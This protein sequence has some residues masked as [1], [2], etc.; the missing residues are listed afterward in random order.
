METFTT[1]WVKLPLLAS[2]FVA[3]P[4]ILYQVWAF[5]A[6]GLYRH[7]KRYV[8]PFLVSG[9]PPTKAAPPKKG[10]KKKPR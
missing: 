3:S 7:E 10:Q 1:V 2:I 8:V 4:W 6:P 9:A 5:I